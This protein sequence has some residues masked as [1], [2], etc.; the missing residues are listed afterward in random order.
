MP[1]MMNQNPGG[2]QA[3]P[4]QNAMMQQ[5]SGSG[6]VMDYSLTP[7]QN[8]ERM[9][10]TLQPPA[11]TPAQNPMMQ[12]MQMMNDPAMMQMMQQARAQRDGQ[13]Q[14]MQLPLPVAPAIVV[15]DEAT[16]RAKYA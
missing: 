5:A 9:R 8:A 10:Q 6:F 2:Y 7:A 15:E 11:Q 12:M 13:A 16:L 3:T 4:D 1:G 14:M